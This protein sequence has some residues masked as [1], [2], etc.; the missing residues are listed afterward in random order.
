MVRCTAG[1]SAI[2]ALLIAVL[3]SLPVLAD[4]EP[5]SD[6]ARASAER[7]ET[8]RLIQSE[9]PKW[10][11]SR[12]RGRETR[13][14]LESKPALRWTNPGTAR[15]YGELY[16]WTVRGRP[17]AALTLF[18]GWEP[19]WGFTAEMTSLSL[20]EIVG[21]REGSV[22]WNP[23]KPGIELRGVPDASAPATTAAGRLRQ[24]KALAAGFSAVM[25][26]YRSNADGERQTLRLLTQPVFQYQ[27][28][29][30]GIIDGA[31]FAFVLGTDSEVLLLLEARVVNDK[32]TWQYAFARMN[33]DELFGLYKDAEV[34]R[35]ERARYNQPRETYT[36]IGIDE[37]PAK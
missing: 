20:T 9:L 26:D 14:Q 12:G 5:D 2:T 21:E 18:K 36:W 17:E 19:A 22:V 35:V 15:V 28:T 10:K 7:K 24:M 16:V 34:W 11:I 13:L 23:D 6:K 32:P 30:P 1:T 27:S 29:D 33:N 8:E 37:A 25:V 4:D 31:M 3:Q